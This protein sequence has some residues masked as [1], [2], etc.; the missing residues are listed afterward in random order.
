ME[1][2]N[3]KRNDLLAGR[4]SGQECQSLST[5]GVVSLFAGLE[6]LFLASLPTPRSANTVA[7]ESQIAMAEEVYMMEPPK[8][9]KDGKMESWKRCDYTDHHRSLS[10]HTWNGCVWTLDL[11]EILTGASLITCWA[12][13]ACTMGTVA[14]GGCATKFWQVTQP[15]YESLLKVRFR[16]HFFFFEMVD[17]LQWTVPVN[18]FYMLS[19]D[20]AKISLPFFYLRLSPERTFRIVI[21]ILVSLVGLYALIYA[22]VSLFGCQPIKAS[23]D[24]AAQAT[25]KCV[26]KFGF[27]LAASVANVVMDLKMCLLF[28][29]TT[30]DFV[31]IVAIY[32]CAL[33][34]KLFSNPNYTWG[35][36]YEL[37]WTYAELAGCVI[38]ASA[39]SLK[40]FFKRILPGIFSSHGASYGGPSGAT[41]GSNAIKSRRQLSRKQADAIEDFH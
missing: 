27:F 34:V 40:P 4:F 22:M 35:L 17:V 10:V 16:T 2:L 28:L 5:E 15:Q 24:L 3:M 29:F 39:S 30:G 7:A 32:N 37:C 6:L 23:W 36:A 26:D 19:S 14:Q 9:R 41:G 18:I 38:C 13:Y 31:I 8:G 25:G 12:L 11:D 33:T 20:L 1:N 21:Y